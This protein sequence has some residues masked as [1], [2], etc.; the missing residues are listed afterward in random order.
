MSN[1]ND[2]VTQRECEL[3]QKPIEQFKDSIERKIRSM[4]H[5]LSRIQ[6]SL[7]GACLLLIA[8]LLTTVFNIKFGK[9]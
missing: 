5:R 7:F 9:G 4:E 6:Y 2:H 8:N 1:E 3:I